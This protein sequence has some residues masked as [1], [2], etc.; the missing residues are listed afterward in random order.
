MTP[1]GVCM[2]DRNTATVSDVRGINV[3]INELTP[4]RIPNGDVRSPFVTPGSTAP[5]FSLQIRP[6]IVSMRHSR[7]IVIMLICQ[8]AV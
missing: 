1:L 3:S 4:K 7:S 8:P 5:A 6:L 2:D